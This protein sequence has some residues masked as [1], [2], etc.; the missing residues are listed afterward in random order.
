MAIVKASY[1]KSREGAKATIRYIAHRPGREGE[2]TNRLLWTGEGKLD[3]QTAYQLIDQAPASST[4][5]RFAISPDLRHEDSHKDLYLRSVTEATME[6]LEER[7]GKPVAWVAATHADHAP[8]RHVHVVAVLQ[9]RLRPDDLRSLTHRATQE[10]REQRLERDA[11]R[12]A[13]RGREEELQ[14]DWVLY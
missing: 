4:F 2:Q 5:Y 3:R 8:N 12:E 1:T 6:R 10:C 14:W 9:E 11:V 7:V 13:Q